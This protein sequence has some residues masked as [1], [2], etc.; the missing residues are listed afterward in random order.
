MTIKSKLTLNVVTVLGVIVAVVLA[1]VIGMGFV[2][3]SSMT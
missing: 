2:K 3:A 1:S